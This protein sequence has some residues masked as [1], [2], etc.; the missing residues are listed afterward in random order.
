[1]T[2]DDLVPVLLTDRLRLRAHRLDDF[3]A[4]AAMWADGQVVAHISGKP[5]TEG[6]TWSRLLRYAGHW[7]H[8]GFGYWAVEDRDTG[9]FLGEVGFA[10]YH[11]DTEPGLAGTPEAGWVFATA[12][13]GRGIATEA[14]RAMLDWADRTLPHTRTAAIFDPGHAA[15]IGVARKI[16]FGGDVTGRYGEDPA[17]FLFRDRPL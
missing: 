14:V 1:M 3:P 16:G 6:E 8:L 17:L 2:S 15:A 10:D 5:S 13:H 7:L 12:A 9:A 4:C 11:R